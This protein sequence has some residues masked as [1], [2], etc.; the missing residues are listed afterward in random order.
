[1]VADPGKPVLRKRGTPPAK[2]PP[3]P[4]MAIGAGAAPPPA[5]GLD[6]SPPPAAGAAATG[7]F[8]RTGTLLS[9]VSAFFSFPFLNPSMDDNNAPLS[10]FIGGGLVTAGGGG[11]PGGGGGGGMFVLLCFGVF[12]F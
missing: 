3:I 11:G 5:A 4:P 1:M 12:R 2:S 7:L 8:E 6:T 10:L 9:T